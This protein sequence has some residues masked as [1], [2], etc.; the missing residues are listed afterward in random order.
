MGKFKDG[1]TLRVLAEDG[2]HYFIDYRT[3]SK[4][5]GTA[6]GVYNGIPGLKSSKKLPIKIEVISR[7]EFDK[8]MKSK[9]H[10]KGRND[11]HSNGNT[12]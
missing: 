6:G 4:R 11:S 12:R 2:H 8:L 5:A 9:N 10:D 3:K 7:E 1:G